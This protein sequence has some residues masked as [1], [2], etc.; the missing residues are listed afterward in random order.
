MERT[1]R[2]CNLPEILS[3]PP[4]ESLHMS[5][6]DMPK[7]AK[8]LPAMALEEQDSGDNHPSLLRCPRQG[9]G[10]HRGYFC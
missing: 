3:L 1:T 8:L 10:L 6:R 9:R 4:Q 5:R 2:S 7:M